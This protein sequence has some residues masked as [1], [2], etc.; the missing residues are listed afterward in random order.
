MNPVTL[1]LL[2]VVTA[3][4]FL[5][6][7][8]DSREVTLELRGALHPLFKRL[9]S[10]ISEH[11]FANIYLFRLAHSYRVSAI[12]GGPGENKL[13][14][15]GVDDGEGFFMLPFG[16]PGKDALERFLSDFR[17]MKSVSGEDARR[18]VE[19]G[20][21]A[22][23]DRDNFDYLYLREELVKLSG[24]KFHKK[25]N[26]VNAF[27]GEHSCV[28]RPL[29]ASGDARRVLDEWR[30]TSPVPGDYGA[31]AEALE[32]TEELQL[33]GAMY[34]VDD[35][36]AAWVLGEELKPDTFVVHFEKG[37]EGVK[38][39]LQFVNQSFTAILPEKYTYVNWEQDL[40]DEG[41]RHAKMSYRPSGFVKK[42]RVMR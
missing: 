5:P 33:C 40:G 17:F 35:S 26:L 24:R 15:S 7:Y 1:L 42:F 28:G 2:G 29:L 30:R 21:R 4:K 41:L 32:L 12:E 8:P 3:D 19:M 38:G 10:P 27:L 37:I 18:L 39:L 13:L 34:Y 23:E 16:L 31:A 36:P 14:I 6:I 22:E 20:Y 11:T 9:S 25:K